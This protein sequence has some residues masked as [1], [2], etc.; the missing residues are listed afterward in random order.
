MNGIITTSDLIIIAATAIICEVAKPLAFK[1]KILKEIYPYIVAILAMI[2]MVIVSAIN[3]TL[4]PES[5]LKGLIDG[6]VAAWCYDAIISK[7][8][9][10]IK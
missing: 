5:V 3:G 10:A 4:S 1:V 6:A 8:K 2:L 9:A 7:L